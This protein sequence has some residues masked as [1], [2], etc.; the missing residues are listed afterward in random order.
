MTDTAPPVAVDAGT[1]AAELLDAIE[2]GRPIEPPTGRMPLDVAAAYRVAG[3]L[4]HL[5]EARGARHAGRKIGFSNR[6][7]WPVYGIDAPIWGDMFTDTV[8]DVSPGAEVGLGR[9]ME[10]RIEPE[11]AF[12]LAAAP[13]AGMTDA[14]VLGCCAWI[15]HGV[16]L[17]HSP[18]PG[19]RFRTADTIA[20]GGLHG[21]LL[22]G[23]RRIAGPEW[24]TPLGDFTCHLSRDG[25]HQAEGH[26]SV[27]LDGPLPALRHLAVVLAADPES[28]PLASGE[29]VTTGTLTDALP[30][31]PGQ[32]WTTRL[33]GLDL[34]GIDVRFA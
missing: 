2:A 19:W 33:S 1:L 3:A 31:A 20:A 6:T 23:P 27:V 21:M 26:G 5:R 17:V 11:I 34:P 16:E 30:V 29:I 28:P 8:H 18:Y 32:R 22:L 12:G 14:E 10:P 7:I 15:A 25:E 9:L 13:S 4:R 24:L